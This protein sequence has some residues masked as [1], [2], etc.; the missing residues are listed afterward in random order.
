MLAHKV[1]VFKC[2]E[3]LAYTEMML[4]FLSDDLVCYILPLSEFL[5]WKETYL[6]WGALKQSDIRLKRH[7][8]YQFHKAGVKIHLFLSDKT[9]FSYLRINILM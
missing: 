9:S 1:I 8:D 4:F 2:S 7:Y 3:C 5:T 6:I